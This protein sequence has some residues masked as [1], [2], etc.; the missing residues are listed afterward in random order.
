[1]TVV[2]MAIMEM[3][4]M[5]TTIVDVAIAERC[6]LEVPSWTVGSDAVKAASRVPATVE[7]SRATAMKPSATSTVTTML[8][9]CNTARQQDAERDER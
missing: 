3:A 8:S 4:I 5:E 7:S 2:E 6:S 9:G 1:M